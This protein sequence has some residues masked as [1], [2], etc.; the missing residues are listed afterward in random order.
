MGLSL[1][2][3]LQPQRP[4]GLSLSSSVKLPILANSSKWSFCDWLVALRVIFLSF[5]HLY[6]VSVLESFLCLNSPPLWAVYGVTQ[7]SAQRLGGSMQAKH[8]FE[9]SLGGLWSQTVITNILK[10][11]LCVHNTVCLVNRVVSICGHCE[12]YCTELCCTDSGVLALP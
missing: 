10:S 1:L 7:L 12:L 5:V 6:H 3:P 9:A 4:L 8:G 2:S 11:V